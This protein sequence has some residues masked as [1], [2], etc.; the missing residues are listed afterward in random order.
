MTSD[1]LK[2]RAEEISRSGGDGPL[3]ET[4]EGET[5]HSDPLTPWLA[6]V[7]DGVYDALT[8]M[9]RASDARA[10]VHPSEPMVV[11]DRHLVVPDVTVRDGNDRPVLVV[12]VR[13]DSSDRY[14]LGMKRLAYQY[15]EVPEY[16]FIDP[17]A[18]T[19]ERLVLRNRIDGFTWPPQQ[20]GP[21]E[22]IDLASVGTAK[23]SVDA[24]LSGVVP[25]NDTRAAQ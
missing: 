23:V 10:T 14:A 8:A 18:G 9:A 6:K 11:L 7:L 16:W 4:I 1:D 5:F 12:E 22:S 15:A 3:L 21:G 13:S 24:L 2:L 19:V 25:A 17:R 20:C